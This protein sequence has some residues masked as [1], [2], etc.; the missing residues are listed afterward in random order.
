MK[1]LL[2]FCLLTLTACSPSNTTADR[3]Q[4]LDFLYAS[5]PLPDSVDYSRDYWLENIDCALQARQEMPWGKNIPEREFRHFV[6]P[7]RVNNENLDD[8]RT[9]FYDE[10][11]P[12]V[13]GLSM[14]DAIL[15]VNHWCHEKVT[16][17]PSDERTSSPLATIRSAIGRCGEESTFL[18]SALRSVGIPA[19]QV[20]TPR[21]A[22][23]DDNHAWVEAWADGEWHFLGACEPEA[24]LDLGWFNAPASRGMLM[25]TKAFG[26][27]DGPEEVMQRTACYTEIDVTSNYA[28]VAK[29]YVQVVDAK[30]QPVSDAT[31]EFKIYN[32]AEFYTVS[33]KQTDANGMTYMQAGLGD[34][35]VWAYRTVGEKPCY[36]AEYG[37]AACSIR[38]QADTMQVV[39][40]HKTGDEFSFDLEIVPPVERNTLPAVSEEQQA[41]NQQRLAQEDSIRNAY[42]S[43]FATDD[44]LL[45]ASRGNHQTIR[46]FLNHANDKAKAEGLLH[47]ISEKDLRDVVPEV[48]EDHYQ[49][50]PARYCQ[51]ND[52]NNYLL[53]P[54]VLNERL[55]PYK[56]YF[57]Q[58]LPEA[59][60]AEFKLDVNNII[61]WIKNNITID[62]LSNPQQ[63]RMTPMGVWQSRRCDAVSRDIFFVALARSMGHLAYVNR[64]DGTVW[65]KQL[66]S[67]EWQMVTLETQGPDYEEAEYV[68]YDLTLSYQPT[69]LLPDP[70]YYTHFTLSELESNG[71]LKLLEYGEDETCRSLSAEPLHFHG[72][73]NH[74]LI[75]GTRMANGSVLVHG[76]MIAAQ[77]LT[78]KTAPLIMR[79]ASEGLQ[80]IGSLNAE[81][82][83]Q[84]LGTAS[85]WNPQV[86]FTSHEGSLLSTTG[87]GFYV[88][89]IIAPNNEPTNHT[90]R[91][92]AQYREALEAWG[93]SLML[94]FRNEDEARRFCLSDFPALPQNTHF[95]IDHTGAILDEITSSLHLT[96][97]TLPLFVIA[98]TFNRIVFLSEG[99]TIGLGEQLVKGLT[100]E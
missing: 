14:A 83:Y 49:H 15:E 22:H 95:G 8:S 59:L 36:A 99:Y 7:V 19:R 61:V 57:L 26:N 28:P 92:I 84:K 74:L 10:L 9:L 71:H 64:V 18:V 44:D 54:R 58:T 5:M 45:K 27:Y 48:L 75:T 67:G 47:A 4:L 97:Q 2:P 52:Y 35:L 98:D 79:Q 93:G 66:Q 53:N 78:K 65:C 81:H 69:A 77:D 25:H 29:N 63:L 89:G 62:E 31:V 55:T 3:E 46:D 39:L 96:S 90:L 87:R 72:C 42:V 94:L 32:Y 17:Q 13:S 37:Y 51:V 23:T 6:L 11:K 12:R 1:R 16:Y 73:L 21:W 43:T 88:L 82:L 76:E 33:T 80:V 38:E 91:D 60:L 30:G 34:L 24:V 68:R 20:Y 86:A 100:A 56:Q 70:K 41:Y 40:A 50:T 85:E